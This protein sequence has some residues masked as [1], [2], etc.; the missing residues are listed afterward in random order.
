MLIRTHTHIGTVLLK[1]LNYDVILIIQ[2]CLIPEC[3]IPECLINAHA[4]LSPIH[5]SRM[6]LFSSI[7]FHNPLLIVILAEQHLFAQIPVL[8]TKVHLA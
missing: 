6:C 1:I 8:Y 5:I 3:L 7:V 4:L 2:Y